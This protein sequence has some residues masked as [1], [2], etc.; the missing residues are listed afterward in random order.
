MLI[1]NLAGYRMLDLKGIFLEKA[2]SIFLQTF[3]S[4]AL[5]SLASRVIEMAVAI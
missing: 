1:N 5:L 2:G 3:E 4:I